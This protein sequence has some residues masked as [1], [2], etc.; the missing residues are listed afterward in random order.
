M[1][2]QEERIENIKTCAEEQSQL[3]FSCLSKVDLGSLKNSNA[4]GKARYHYEICVK[5]NLQ[6]YPCL[7]KRDTIIKYGI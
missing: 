2:S 5:E 1:A 6:N 4:I 7:E 3:Q